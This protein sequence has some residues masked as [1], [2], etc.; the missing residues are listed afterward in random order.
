MLGIY[1]EAIEMTS[2]WYSDAID[3]HS[4]VF[5]KTENYAFLSSAALSCLKW[6]PWSRDSSITWE[7]RVIRSHPQTSS[8]FYLKDTNKR[9]LILLY[10]RKLIM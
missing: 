10:V 9:I 4:L 7:M 8:R 5:G 2:A 3:N 6:G 1:K